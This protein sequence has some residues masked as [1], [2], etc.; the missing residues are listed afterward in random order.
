MDQ[1]IMIY[2]ALST[3]EKFLES[4]KVWNTESQV[5][6]G[7]VFFLNLGDSV[8]LTM[9]RPQALALSLMLSQSVEQHDAEKLS[10]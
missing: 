2:G 1:S 7:T 3:Y 5:T 6:N 4:V 9:T 10:K 8:T